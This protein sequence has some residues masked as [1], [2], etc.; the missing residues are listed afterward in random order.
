MSRNNGIHRIRPDIAPII[1]TM[2]EPSL[3]RLPVWENKDD[4]IEILEKYIES[5]GKNSEARVYLEKSSFIQSLIKRTYRASRTCTIKNLQTIFAYMQANNKTPILLDK[6]ILNNNDPA[7]IFDFIDMHMHGQL[8]TN[9]EW[10]L[11]FAELE[12]WDLI[13]SKSWPNYNGYIIST[14]AQSYLIPQIQSLVLEINWG[15]AKIVTDGENYYY[16][17][18]DFTIDNMVPIFG[19]QIQDQEYITEHLSYLA[20]ESRMDIYSLLNVD[21]IDIQEWLKDQ[22]EV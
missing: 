22:E 6:L 4:L 2:L 10:K 13:D 11:L 15:Y 9:T 14:Y 17:E 8:N 5:D 18:D 12:Q 20:K 16:S 1:R 3:H 21:P 7:G 19:R